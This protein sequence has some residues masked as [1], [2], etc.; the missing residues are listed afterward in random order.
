MLRSRL[1]VAFAA[2]VSVLALSRAALAD[3]PARVG[4]ISYVEGQ[5]SLQPPE[6]SGWAEAVPNF[7]VTSGEALWT[8]ED[9]RAELEFG[10]VQARLDAQTELDVLDL[11]YGETRLSLPQGSADLRVW[12]VPRGG[13]TIAT[14]AGEVRI[15]QPGA[16]RIDV[17]A[18]TDDGSYPPVE[19][20]T[21]EGD[22]GAPGQ[23]GLV[24]VPAGASAVIYAGYDPDLSDA[25]T[26]DIDDW[27][28]EREARFRFGS[29]VPAA[30]TGYE[31]LGAY[32]DFEQT[33][34]YG[35]VWFPRD[36]PADWAP[37]RY[38]RWAYV[39]PWGWTWIDDQ[40]WGFAPFHYGRWAQFGGR[41]GWVPGQRL[42]EPVY[43]PALVAFFG[44][45]GFGVSV[46]LGGGGAFGWAPL[47][48]DE[49]YIPP[50]RVSQNYVR[51]VNVANVNTTIIN[52]Y[53]VN[54][55]QPVP[56][57]RLRNVA[58]ATVAPADAIS[59]GVKIQQAAVRVPPQ[60]LAQ[61]RQA[62]P[63]DAPPPPPRP[64][65]AGPGA[66]G[67]QPG[68]AAALAGFRAAA[69]PPPRVEALRK[70]VAQAAPGSNQPPPI[71]GAHVAASKPALA[72]G[73]QP[74]AVAPS[75][76]G[77]ALRPSPPPREVGP[78]QSPANAQ[79]QGQG[80]AQ[81]SQR[82]LRRYQPAPSGGAGQ[83]GQTPADQALARD[84]ARAAAQAKAR[85]D[86][87]AAAAARQ[88]QQA[89]RDAQA[90]AQAQAKAH[91]DA[92]AAARA[93]QQQDQ[94]ARD[95][96]I[97][98]RDQARAEAQAKARADA[99]AA[100]RARQLQQAETQAQDRARADAE[101]ATR[102]R[103]QQQA[104]REA[105]AQDRAR[106]AA[107]AKARTD[108]EA[109]AKAHQQNAKTDRNKDRNGQPP[110]SDQPPL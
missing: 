76:A 2:G 37:Y 110:A 11:E 63:A 5:V 98:A 79:S 4:R 1:V 29:A 55:A 3:P 30:E 84:Q 13:V 75:F 60:A 82:P 103:Q 93:R 53:V 39:N 108:A 87:D 7:P 80:A 36:M 26:A 62:P 77:R 12:R 50:Y 40:P 81:V 72:P 6:D 64:A 16:Y 46:Q 92:E 49:P 109:A 25:Q 107:E 28:R 58:A 51:Q 19:V 54:G 106:A 41:W 105:Q 38:G 43:A 24:D 74:P 91:A 33:P 70:A 34:D 8:G 23:D 102:A 68:R 35:Q 88:Q 104:D 86:A 32:G 61:V 17:G 66:G 94:A 14:P 27:A 31:D 73:S 20:T 89:D 96:Q 59:R 10:P 22:A 65:P 52:N 9:G 97:Q 95:A 48:P 83:P 101:A 56:P 67:Q 18:P 42:A 57:A 99:E 90:Q 47:A 78:P 44:G 100:T 71:P 21:F 15:D 45:S 69:P 85:A